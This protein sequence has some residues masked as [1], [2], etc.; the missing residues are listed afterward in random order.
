MRSI[1]IS[2]RWR[3]VGVG[4]DLGTTVPGCALHRSLGSHAPLALPSEKYR[5]ER[6]ELGGAK[7]RITEPSEASSAAAK[8]RRISHRFHRFHR[9][10]LMVNDPPAGRG[11]SEAIFTKIFF[12]K[13]EWSRPFRASSEGEIIF[14][15]LNF[16]IHYMIIASDKPRPPTGR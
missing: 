8:Y 12:G 9:Y 1:L 10:F 14:R 3:S 11:L 13:R 15:K 2:H 6:S 16:I 5:T 7:Y 4:E